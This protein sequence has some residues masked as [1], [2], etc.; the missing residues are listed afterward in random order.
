MSLNIHEDDL[1]MAGEKIGFE[2]GIRKGRRDGIAAGSYQKARETAK[3]MQRESCS[4][5]FIQR[6][7]GLSEAEIKKL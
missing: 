3:L 1:R 4:I 2:R 5:D 7:T 6:M